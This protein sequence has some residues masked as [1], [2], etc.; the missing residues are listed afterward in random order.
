[1]ITSRAFDP[2]FLSKSFA[3]LWS[4]GWKRSS[5]CSQ[6]WFFRPGVPGYTPCDSWSLCPKWQASSNPLWWFTTRE[7]SLAFRAEPW[8]SQCLGLVPGRTPG[9]LGSKESHVGSSASRTVAREEGW[10]LAEPW[11]MNHFSQVQ[12][13]PPHFMLFLRCLV[14]FMYWHLSPAL[15]RVLSGYGARSCSCQ[16]T[17]ASTLAGVPG[18][19]QPQIQLFLHYVVKM[20]IL[21]KTV[22]P[23][24][25]F[26]LCHRIFISKD[27]LGYCMI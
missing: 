21:M 18:S 26:C 14:T 1:M 17:A 9:G 2:P 5:W 27:D 3:L 25:V 22:F 19:S 23:F 11:K 16:R 10:R 15:N 8:A 24:L 12:T 6:R 13:H 4:S 20:L 7:C